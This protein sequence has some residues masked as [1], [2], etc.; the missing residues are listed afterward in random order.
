[1]NKITIAELLPHQAPMLLLDR[2]LD[3]QGARVRCETR[4]GVQHA[5]LL[6][7]QGNLP[8]WVGIELMAQTIAA[9]AGMRGRERDEPVRIGMLLGSRQYQSQVS[10]FAAG[11]RLIIEAECLLEDGG[12]ASFECRILSGDRP[13]AEARLSTY[14]PSE[15]ELATLLDTA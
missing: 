5:L 6:D 7:E 3:Y 11:Q 2:L 1:M 15:G 10:A 13:C 8:A 9:W 4:V 12:M 14:L